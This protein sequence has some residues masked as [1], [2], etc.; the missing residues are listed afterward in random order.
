VTADEV[1][2]GL[3]EAEH[4]AIYAYGVLGA[5][6]DD[7]TR[8]LALSAHDA[9]RAARDDLQRL[10]TSRGRDLP[11]PAPAYDVTVAT[12]AQAVA[13]A[14][15]LEDDLAGR[16]H[17]LVADPG[18]RPRAVQGLSDSAVRAA[19]WRRKAGPRP[20]TQAFPGQP[21]Q[22]SSSSSSPSSPGSTASAST[23]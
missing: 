5:R 16:W 21:A 7:A 9:H 3:L 8:R 1:L 11:V 22:A 23:S 17:D 14:V 20:W 15:R 19:L 13:L 10:L 12:R 18:L 2:A 4:A 6:L